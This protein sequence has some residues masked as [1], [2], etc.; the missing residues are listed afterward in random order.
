MYFEDFRHNLSIP[1]AYNIHIKGF[2][3]SDGEVKNS[4]F[5]KQNRVKAL[6][7]KKRRSLN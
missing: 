7:I 6:N 1:T 2:R 5:K 4:P 3:K